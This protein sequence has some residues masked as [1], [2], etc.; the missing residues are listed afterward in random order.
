MII[1]L[2]YPHKVLWP[3]GRTQNSAYKR[4]LQKAHKTWA[5]NAA[6]AGTKKLN[7]CQANVCIRVSAMLKGPLPDED[8]IIAACKYYLDGIS[9]ATNLN[10]R[11]F[12]APTIEFIERSQYGRI[13]IEVT[14]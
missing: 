12:K 3:N 10:D 9:L 2:Q 11:F 5:F 1:D 8:N 6:G 7:Q 14:Q 13:F 4:Q